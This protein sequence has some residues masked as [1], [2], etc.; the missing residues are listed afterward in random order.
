MHTHTQT[1]RQDRLQYTAPLSLT[2]S[3]I[4]VVVMVVVAAAAAAAIYSP[5][6]SNIKPHKGHRQQT[7]DV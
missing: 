2:R 6:S 5:Q 7:T 4:M 3:V 1:H